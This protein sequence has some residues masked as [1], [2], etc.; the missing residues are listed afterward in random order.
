MQLYII[1]FWS[2][3]PVYQIIGINFLNIASLIYF[4]KS[5]PF[6][7]ARERR[8]EFF[9]EACLGII[10]YFLFLYTDFLPDED[11]KYKIGW[12]Q[13]A[14]FG[15]NVGVNSYGVL[16]FM[17]KD[18]TLIL[19]R[20]YLMI[21]R[22]FRHRLKPRQPEVIVPQSDT[23]EESRTIDLGKLDKKRKRQSRRG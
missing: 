17:A 1:F 6:H 11:L 19:A 3:T 23:T 7:T 15:L 2:H 20:K 21:R 12:G 13:V 5:D 18:T 9:N 14:I 10:A 4:G 8:T 22:W 16:H